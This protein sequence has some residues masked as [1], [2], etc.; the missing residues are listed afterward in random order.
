MTAARRRAPP[1]RRPQGAVA[2]PFAVMLPVMLDFV[3]LAIDRSMVYARSFKLQHLAV[4]AAHELDGTLAGFSRARSKATAVATGN[5]YQFK[6]KFSDGPSWS[7]A[8]LSFSDAPNGVWR[9]GASITSETAAAPIVYA[10]V[11]TTALQNLSAAP[12]RWDPTFPRALGAGSSFTAATVAVAGRVGMRDSAKQMV[13]RSLIAAGLAP[14]SARTALVN[15][16]DV[17]CPGVTACNAG[18]PDTIIVQAYLSV[19]DPVS[20]SMTGRL[21]GLQA[22]S[23]V[24]YEN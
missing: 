12:G 6:N 3:G 14:A 22:F 24:R 1:R 21:V 7:T 15:Q 11:D 4:A 13:A 19:N 17:L 5:Y 10:Q 8:A 23:T 2:V 20:L 16:V 18:T 9:P